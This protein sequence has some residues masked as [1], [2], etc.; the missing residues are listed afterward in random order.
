MRTV[1]A[2]IAIAASACRTENTYAVVTVPPEALRAVVATPAAHDAAV[3]G[4]TPPLHDGRWG[5]ANLEVCVA[6]ITSSRSD[7]D[8][9]LRY[10]VA[11]SDSR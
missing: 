8:V 2:A 10:Q 9:T 7:K 5:M 11:V 3:T 4:V 6:A 1:V